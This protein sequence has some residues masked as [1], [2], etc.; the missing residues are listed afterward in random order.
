MHGNKQ[1]ALS[2]SILFFRT[3]PEKR[4]K[5]YSRFN[6]SVELFPENNTGVSSGQLKNHLYILQTIRTGSAFMYSRQTVVA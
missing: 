5:G 6:E 4:A 2:F 3:L 1:P